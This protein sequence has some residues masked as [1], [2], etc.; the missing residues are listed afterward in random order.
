M[1]QSLSSLQSCV[2]TAAV[3]LP[4]ILYQVLVTYCLH[5]PLVLSDCTVLTGLTALCVITGGNK[6]EEEE[7]EEED[8]EDEENGTG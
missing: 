6:E 2:R 3:I 5:L 7:G 8:E 1:V 4:L